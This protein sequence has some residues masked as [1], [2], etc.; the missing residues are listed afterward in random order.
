MAK[1]IF[2]TILLFIGAVLLWHSAAKIQSGLASQSWPT[3]DAIVSKSGFHLDVPHST[4]P[5]SIEMEYQFQV[6]E[7][8]YSS[9][10]VG[11][12]P[13]KTSSNFARPKV[14]EKIQIRYEPGNPKQS[15]V[16]PGIP[17]ATK[18]LAAIGMILTVLGFGWLLSICLR[19]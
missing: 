12:G 2:P 9:T 11:F 3:A 8:L 10:R 17:K 14:G 6:G 18:M 1:F 7:T 5:P 13:V 4:A 16:V 15:V 19:K